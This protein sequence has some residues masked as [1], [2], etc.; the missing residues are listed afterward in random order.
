MSGKLT[1][2]NCC[3]SKLV[4]SARIA[5]LRRPPLRSAAQALTEVARAATARRSSPNNPE[6]LRKR[7]LM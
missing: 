6:G 7:S 1:V 5:T 4:M 2:E 3:G